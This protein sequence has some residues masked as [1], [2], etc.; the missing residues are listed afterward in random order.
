M[1]AIE[2]FLPD[3]SLC[4]AKE[5]HRRMLEHF[6]DG[7]FNSFVIDCSAGVI[8]RALLDSRPRLDFNYRSSDEGSLKS[9]MKGKD[10]VV[11]SKLPGR[12]FV[13]FYIEAGFEISSGKYQLSESPVS[14]LLIEN[15]EN[16]VSA[17]REVITAIFF[18]HDGYPIYLVDLSKSLED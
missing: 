14:P 15:I 9:I 16:A 10:V 4:D 12:G 13:D 7:S 17:F 11:L 3:D 5:T 18:C 8:E 2:L 1:K 6:V